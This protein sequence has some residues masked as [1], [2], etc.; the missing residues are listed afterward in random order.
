MKHNFK[1]VLFLCNI[2]K[3]RLVVLYMESC[4]FVCEDFPKENQSDQIRTNL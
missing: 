3:I 2:L 1:I 4:G